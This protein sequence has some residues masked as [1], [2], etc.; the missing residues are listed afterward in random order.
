M[1]GYALLNNHVLRFYS[2]K[3]LCSIVLSGNVCCSILYVLLP[4]IY[5]LIRY[6]PFI[7]GTTYVVLNANM[8]LITCRII[9]V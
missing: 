4:V 3:R 5:V 9:A 6:F 7:Y 2:T 8:S 1:L